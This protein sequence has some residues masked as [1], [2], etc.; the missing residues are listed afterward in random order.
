MSP[1]RFG[2]TA[3]PLNASEHVG[4]D[5]GAS[6]TRVDDRPCAERVF[7]V[8]RTAG[9]HENTRQSTNGRDGTQTLGGFTLVG[10]VN[11]G[12]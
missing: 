10:T 12:S 7:E 2:S 9:L 4:R 1:P 3:A 6:C 8:S 11:G 5:H